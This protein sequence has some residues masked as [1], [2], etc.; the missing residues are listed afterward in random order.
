MQANPIFLGR[1]SSFWAYVKL[2]SE[3]LGY[4]KNGAVISH[5][6]QAVI[7][8]F[9]FLKINIEEDVLD[10]A[11]SYIEYRAELLNSHEHYL[12]DAA[13]AAKEFNKLLEIF[14]VDT[15]T[16]NIPM[17]KQSGEKK[18]VAYLT[19]IVNILTESTI[20]KF[21]DFHGLEYGKDIGFNHDPRSLSYVLSEDRKLEGI[22]SRRFDGA[23]PDVKNAHLIWEL[24]EYYYTTSFGSK[25]SGAVYETQ[26][27]GYEVKTIK[28]DTGVHINHVLIVDAHGTWWDKGKP[29]LCRVVDMLH[30]GLA[31]EVLLGKEV[32]DRWPVIVEKSLIYYKE[33]FIDK[34]SI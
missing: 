31:D 4:S 34:K 21:A 30:A 15:Y 18:Q 26:L 33:N 19:G 32:F 20:R 16:S 11:L 13:T 5:T 28:E 10:E 27:D 9:T 25:I 1:D 7:S 29:Y 23:F 6:K 12:M 22:M 2:I 8:K 17:N 24:K 14:P 3:Q